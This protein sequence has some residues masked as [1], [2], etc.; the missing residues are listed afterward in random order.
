MPPQMMLC[1]NLKIC[2]MQTCN[3]RR[4]YERIFIGFTKDRRNK[5]EVEKELAPTPEEVQG[6]QT[7]VREKGDQIM[8]I[9]LDSLTE[10]REFVQAIET[11]G[12]ATIQ[13]SQSKNS[14]LQTRMGDFSK[15]GGESGDVA[16][17]WRSFP[18]RWGS[19]PLW[20]GLYKDRPAGKGV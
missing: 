2:L 7:A 9:D 11:F 1:I 3:I 5:K 4:A 19:G 17:D 20:S 6:I 13:K 12:A 10:R 15:A 14:I 16:R 8:Q 18:S